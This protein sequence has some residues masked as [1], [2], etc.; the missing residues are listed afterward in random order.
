MKTIP[1]MRMAAQ[2]VGADLT[3]ST[4]LWRINGSFAPWLEEFEKMRPGSAALGASV[5]SF[6]LT[7]ATA[8]RFAIKFHR[9]KKSL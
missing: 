3:E 6:D 9:L 7:A 5:G 2:P 8:L 4:S 1:G